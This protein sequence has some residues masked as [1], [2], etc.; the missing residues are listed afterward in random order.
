MCSTIKESPL[1]EGQDENNYL[2]DGHAHSGGEA[3]MRKRREKGEE[4]SDRKSGLEL[5]NITPASKGRR[6]VY[7]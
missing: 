7:E 4:K 5:G 2:A 3:A 6:T 1:P